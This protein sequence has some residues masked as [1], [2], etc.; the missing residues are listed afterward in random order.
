MLCELEPP[1]PPNVNILHKFLSYLTLFEIRHFKSLI[2]LCNILKWWGG[3]GVGRGVT[4][5]PSH[6]DF[7]KSVQNLPTFKLGVCSEF[8]KG[9]VGAQL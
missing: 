6:I 1:W 2:F 4:T 3:G 7:C 5:P 9:L 8:L